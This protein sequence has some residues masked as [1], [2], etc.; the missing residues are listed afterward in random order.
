MADSQ[1]T[2]DSNAIPQ[3]HRGIAASYEGMAATA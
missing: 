2:T 3:L 1:K